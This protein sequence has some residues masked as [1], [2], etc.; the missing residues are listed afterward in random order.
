LFC[1]ELVTPELVTPELVTPE[2]VTPE[3]VTIQKQRFLR[4]STKQLHTTAEVY[5]LSVSV[6]E[7]H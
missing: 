2:L 4:L 6:Q 1:G 3:L 7:F 5:K